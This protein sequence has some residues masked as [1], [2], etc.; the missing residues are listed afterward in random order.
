MARVTASGGRL[1]AQSAAAHMDLYLGQLGDVGRDPP[2]LMAALETERPP[3][4][5]SY[6]TYPPSIQSEQF[7]TDSE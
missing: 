2:R 3:R 7:Y 6:P 5:A 4:G 1:L